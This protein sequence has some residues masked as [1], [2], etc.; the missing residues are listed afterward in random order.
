[1]CEIQII[2]KLGK[3]KIN[4]SDIGEFFKM[5]CFG[6]MH[7]NDAFGVFNDK[8]M[9]KKKGAFDASKLDEHELINSNFIIGH[10]RLST[11]WYNIKSVN[12]NKKNNIPDISKSKKTT[13]PAKWNRSMSWVDNLSNIFLPTCG[14]GMV[15]LGWGGMKDEEIGEGRDRN[16]NHHPFKL[17]DFI[18]IHNGTISNAQ[19][20]HNKYNFKTN[21]DTDSY[22][23]LELI[24]YFFKRSNVKN[25]VKRIAGAIQ[26]TCEKINGGY[27]V[28]LYDKRGKSTFYFK[29]A[30]TS[31]SLCKY[32]DKILC[33]ST[34]RDNLDYLYFGMDREDI[35]IKNKRV[36]L[37]TSDVTSPVVDV[38]YKKYKLPEAKTLYAILSNKLRYEDKIRKLDIFLEKKLGF[39]PLYE[40]TFMGHLKIARNNDFEIKEKI[41]NIVKKPKKRFGWYIIKASDVKSLNKLKKK[42]KK[43]I[44]AKKVRRVKLNKVKGGKK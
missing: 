42:G 26:D 33:G 27:S 19:S 24:D 37:I 22:I 30:S 2:Q 3:E 15:G 32:G 13:C 14:W 12:K 25:R 40:F 7:N 10:N 34:S 21:I 23:I 43:K 41:Y 39:I 5:M 16:R 31:F 6:S 36:Y 29:N 4:T 9:F 20:L 1:M 28:V 35:Y 38:T 11:G 8:I 17:G 18:L 44:K